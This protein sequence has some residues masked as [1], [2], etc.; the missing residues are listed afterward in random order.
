[1]KLKVYEW[2]LRDQS[3]PTSYDKE[4][5]NPRLVYRL[6]VR[7]ESCGHWLWYI[8]LRYAILTV[9]YQTPTCWVE[10]YVGYCDTTPKVTE[11]KE[12]LAAAKARLTKATNKLREAERVAAGLLDF[13]ENEKLLEMQREKVRRLQAELLSL[14]SDTPK[15][16]HNER[17]RT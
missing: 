16:Q 7:Q 4:N 6:T 14:E 12:K 8:K 9:K 17:D 15:E 3:M 5:P 1:M 13:G 11:H 2:W 10:Q